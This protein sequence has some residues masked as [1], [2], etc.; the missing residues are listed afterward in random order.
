M[1]FNY[2]ELPSAGEFRQ[3]E[4]LADLCE[5][6]PINVSGN[7][8]DE[9]PVEVA[10]VGHPRVILMTPDCDLLGDYKKRSEENRDHTNILL[11]VFLCDMFLL[12]EVRV[13]I[14]GRDIWK[15]IEQNQDE[16]YHRLPGGPIGDGTRG[17]IPD[18][19]LDFKKTLSVPTEILYKAVE[20]GATKRLCMLPPHHLF[21]LVHRFYSFH[22]RGFLPE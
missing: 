13:T 5:Y 22:G 9:S 15:R 6:F 1:P 8:N 17:Q 4:I 11:H 16:R 18:L 7:L 21:H 3:G 19:C 20:S 14:S 12:E 10:R 2:T